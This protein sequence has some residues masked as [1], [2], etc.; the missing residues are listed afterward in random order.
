MTAAMAPSRTNSARRAATRATRP[1]AAATSPGSPAASA[2]GAKVAEMGQF[3]RLFGEH[4]Q[5]DGA[6]LWD[7]HIDDL[8]PSRQ[9]RRVH[10]GEA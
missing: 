3:A 1:T 10:Y 5:R 9:Y 8:I 4:Q 2:S 7:V 6:T